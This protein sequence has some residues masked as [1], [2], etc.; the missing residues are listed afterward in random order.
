[1]NLTI[2]L[3]I[4]VWAMSLVGIA[5]WIRFTISKP[6]YAHLARAVLGWCVH[7]AIF[8]FVVTMDWIPPTT[9]NLWSSAIRIHALGLIIAGGIIMRRV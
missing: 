4:L 6:K 2:A 7:C 3:R 9:L 5:V 8:Y 1:M